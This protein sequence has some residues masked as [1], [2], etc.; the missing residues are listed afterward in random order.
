VLAIGL[1]DCMADF[2]YEMVLAALPLFLTSSLGAPA[3]AV[4]LV[5]GVA[6]GSSA[7]VRVWSGWFSDRVP[8]RKR[9]A[10]AGYST[11]VVGLAT[12]GLIA[13]WPLVVLARGVAWI[14]RGLR[15]PI[16]SS[17][18]AGSVSRRDFG[19]AFG[20]HEAM[21]TL[22]ALLG[23]AVAF[24]LLA[25]GH[26]FG[27]V[28]WV[29]VLPGLLTVAFFAVLT[30]DPRAAAPATAPGGLGTLPPSFW[31]LLVPV[32][33]FGLGNFA[34]AF[35]TLRAAQ[36]LQPELS[37]P[38]AL[39]AA[40]L[41]YLGHQGVGALASFPGGWLADRVGRVPVLAFAYLSF[42][43]ACAVAA[44]GHGPLAVALLALPVGLQAPLV[45]ATENSLAAALVPERLGGTAFG[46]LA[47]VN[48]VGD[49]VS[50]VAAGALWT[51]TGAASALA[52]AALIAVAAA[53]LLLVTGPRLSLAAA[54]ASD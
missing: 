11:T 53:V 4:G 9:L 10:V 54:D 45:V 32:G 17:M 48:G 25:T 16:R 12:I 40:V 43:A 42:A 50:S 14:G 24:A 28:F 33:L 20:F 37:Q 52:A 26:G 41:F 22:G 49:L 21:D 23:P 13:A 27:T 3:Y 29:A 38:V 36:M 6:D 46:V 39:S 2:N 31:R 7:V 35:F 15:Q 8:W 44:L 5:E 19:K 1:A 18:L 30:R 51:A 47:G 34:P